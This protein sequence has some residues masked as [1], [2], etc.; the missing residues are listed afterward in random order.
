[1]SLWQLSI[2]RPVLA[3]VLTIGLTLFG[4]IGWTKLSVRELPDVD[5]PVVSVVTVLPGANPEVVEKEVTE[6][7]EEEI[8]AIEGIKTL[9][10]QSLEQVS[11]ITVEF[12]L[13]RDVNVAAQDVRDK[14]A[15]VRDD[16]PEDAEESVVSKVDL[17]A[18]AIM[19]MS[20]NAP[21]RNLRVISDYAETVVKERLQRVPGVGSIIVGGQ[22]R[23]AVRI[24]LDAQR[25]AA[26]RLTVDDVV[27][28][29]R[30][31]NVEIPSGRIES[32]AREFVVKTE[33]SFPSPEAFN[34]LVIAFR[35]DAP[36]RLHQVGT[37]GEGDEN[38]RGLG[39]F[40]LT[41]TISLGVLKQSNANTVAV[42]QAV[43][44]EVEAMQ[45]ALAPG[46][47]LQIA[48]DAAVFVEESVR[49]VEQSLLLAGLLVVLVI[50]LFLHTPS[51]ALIPAVAIP[52]S[53]VATFGFMY[54]LDF[55][56]NNLT[57]LALTL[58]IGIV[59]DDAIIVLENVHRHMEEGEDRLTAARRGT[60]EIAF[61]A[62]AATVSL[63]AVF[64]PVAFI[65]GIIGRFFYEFG[66]AV[67]VSVVVSLFVALTLTPMLCSR[68]LALDTPRGVFRVFEQLV[69]WLAASYRRLLARALA[70]RALIAAL[71]GASVLASAGLFALLGK[72]FVPP[73]DRAGFMVV[74]ESPEGSTLDYHDRLQRRAEV[75]LSETPE[76]RAA[77]AFIGL[78]QA[79]P[80]APNRGV[81]FTRLHPR[82]ERARGQQEVIAELRE[83]FAGIPGIRVFVIA[84]SGLQTGGG[85]KPFQ[86]VIQH[87][88]FAALKLHSDRL[89]ERI[90]QLPGF[91]EVN[92]NLRLDKPELRVRLDRDKAAALGVS[93]SDVADTL[94]VLLGAAKVSKFKRGNERYDVF[95]QLEETDRLSPAQLGQIYTRARSG[96]LV[97]LASLVDVAEGVGPSSLHHYNRRRSAIIDANLRDK[98][99]GTALDEVGALAR[100]MLPPGFTT[101]VAGESKDFAESFSSL[102]FTFAL[103]VVTVYLVLA[104][105]FESFVHPFTILLT[106]PL[107]VVGAFAALAALGMTLNVYSFIGVVMLVGLVTKNSILLVDYAN[108]QRDEGRPVTEAVLEAGAVRLRPILMT[109]LSTLVGTLPV[110]IGLGAG[111]ESRRPLGVAVVGGLTVS[112]LLTLVVV[113][114]VY[115]LIDDARAI[116]AAR[117]VRATASLTARRPA[118]RRSA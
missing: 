41:P 7:L 32:R 44:T 118:D 51:S 63:V 99:L 115:T 69:A 24:R 43:R 79:G 25:L 57:L 110:A 27:Q 49:E 86:F 15:R 19:W 65:S 84:F 11:L 9:T 18:Q 76:V 46:Y 12:D 74:L 23:F 56:I 29:L 104:A 68:V 95:V 54:F 75:I 109:A 55:S 35:E 77:S 40:N 108:R 91:T 8:N 102:L 31:E 3:T 16:L 2:A 1:M 58:S 62:I 85:G 21:T 116:L 113:P 52:V 66:V 78:S 67:A 33:G 87:P 114:V 93:A 4:W 48:F 82:R 36:V 17:D 89:L 100:E 14:I 94:R 107:A 10:S 117:R 28:A 13:D 72:E 83:R 111:A 45:A 96:E 47:R 105:Q 71:A 38:E 61:A 26:Y 34:Q 97:Q 112:T 81:I 30:R 101:A 42:A 98:A 5:F 6:V 59:V 50:V 60:D 64:A 20:L 90:R 88:D 37:A 92:S 70:H 106:L 73:E 39:R 22:K 53:T 103:A 80:G